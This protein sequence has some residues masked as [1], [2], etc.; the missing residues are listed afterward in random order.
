MPAA[1]YAITVFDRA[2]L[3]SVDASQS[4]DADIDLVDGP[5][6]SVTLVVELESPCFPFSKWE[7]EPPPAGQNWPASCDAFDRIASVTADPDGE[8]FELMRTITPF[9]GPL[10]VEVDLTDWAN[11]R[12]GQHALR[13]FVSTWADA[14]GQVSGSAGGWFFSARIEATPGTPPRNVL[15]AVPVFHGDVT[16]E[17]STH[18]IPLEFP[19]GTTAARIDYLV[20]G[21]GGGPV[22]SDC[23]GPADEFCRRQH[24]LRFDG[25]ELGTIVPWRDDC[26]DLCSVVAGRWQWDYCAENPCG[27]IASVQAPRANW[28]P[29]SAV[30]PMSID[31]ASLAIPGVHAFELAIAGIG[32]GG[33]W[34]TMV[35]A[36]AYAD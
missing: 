10:G 13:G 14:A 19:E 15:A 24:T 28:C 18:S 35:T 3:S 23:I 17:A 1:P 32:E 22:G 8:A 34:P 11:A 29:G 4:A 6:S 31:L 20:S 33:V 30:A 5:F 16:A 9:G 21:H 25:V 12:P 26:V 7:D 27:A 2:W 36:Y